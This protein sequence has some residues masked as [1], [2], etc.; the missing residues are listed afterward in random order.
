MTTSGPHR[1]ERGQPRR[2][3]G[4]LESEALGALW[5]AAGPLTP[6]EVQAALGDGLAY[7]TVHTILTRLMDKGLVE[8]IT[9]DGRSRY[10]PVK[11]ATQLA[12]ERMRAALTTGGDRAG[13]LQHFVTSLSPEEE[14]A[15]RA[16][17]DRTDPTS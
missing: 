15:L 2:A 11:D 5:A 10:S 17:L 3:A 9:G 6:A 12:A 13:V 1:P 7:N 4:E 14:T 16:A 8:R